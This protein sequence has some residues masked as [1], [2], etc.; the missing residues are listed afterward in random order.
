[1]KSTLHINTQRFCTVRIY[2]EFSRGGTEDKSKRSLYLVL[3]RTCQEPLTVLDSD[4]VGL[5]GTPHSCTS[6]A[7]PLTMVLQGPQ[8]PDNFIMSSRGVGP[9][10]S[11]VQADF[12]LHEDFFFYVLFM[13]QSG[14]MCEYFKKSC[15]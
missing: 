15:V 13:L 7:V 1:M 14:I 6:A 8:A 10:H 5:L 11:H 3:F 12:I 4:T 2:T 9:E